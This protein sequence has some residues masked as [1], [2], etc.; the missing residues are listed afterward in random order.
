MATD[1]E[2]SYLIK[3]KKTGSEALKA[4]LVRAGY[5]E[6]ELLLINDRDSLVSECLCIA[7]FKTSS[8]HKMASAPL[9]LNA[10]LAILKQQNDAAEAIRKAERE[11]ERREREVERQTREAERAEANATREAERAEANRIAAEANATRDAE[12]ADARAQHDELI[13]QMIRMQTENKA[14]VECAADMQRDERARQTDLEGGV[15]AHLLHKF[16]QLLKVTL[17]KA[18][19][20]DTEMCT[21]LDG[22]K[23]TMIQLKVPENIRGKLLLPFLNERAKLLVVKMPEGTIDNWDEFT[24]TLITGFQQTTSQLLRT[25]NNAQRKPN[26]SFKNFS[27]RLEAMYRHYLN[28]RKV[29][30]FNDIVELLIS[31]RIKTLMSDEMRAHIVGLELETW[32]RPDKLCDVA[33]SLA[34][35][36]MRL[37]EAERAATANWLSRPPAKVVDTCGV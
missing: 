26:E 6:A 12:R 27:F 4:K 11:A 34:T 1:D 22:V 36:N 15:Q 16:G 8:I 24:K 17:V 7:G 2:S 9:D 29:T 18:P 25:L 14:A 20:Q 35:D 30:N 37:R 3:L 32:M 10:M 31:D 33:D 13:L 28:S 21:W 5:S 19:S 23:S